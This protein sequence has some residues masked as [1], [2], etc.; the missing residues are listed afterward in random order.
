MSIRPR[1]SDRA[2][3]KQNEILIGV[4]VVIVCFMIAWPV[5]R[6]ATRIHHLRTGSE[7]VAAVCTEARLSAIGT[8]QI[9]AFR[10]KAESPYYLIEAVPQANPED[11]LDLSKLDEP[12]PTGDIRP[13]TAIDWEREGKMLPDG[14]VFVTVENRSD[15]E[16][17]MFMLNEL[18]PGE[19]AAPKKPLLFFPD[20]TTTNATI[21]LHND[22]GYYAEVILDGEGGTVSVSEPYKTKSFGG[23]QQD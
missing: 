2:G 15:K 10:Y 23:Q 16:D 17:A 11:L 13:D 6:S 22:V 14:V 20:G 7:A 1:K 9:Y 5:I 18:L 12:N 3:W 8:A 19:M 4:A 21:I